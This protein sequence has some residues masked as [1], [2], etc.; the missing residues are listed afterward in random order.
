MHIPDGML[1]AGV[2]AAGYGLTLLATGYSIKKI[3]QSREPARDIP[4]ASL[5]TAAFFVASLVHI[6]V[7]PASVH[8]LLNGLLG[9]IL[10]YYAFPAILVALFLQAVMFGHGGITTLGINAVIM[11]FPAM[12]CSII[13]RRFKNSEQ[14]SISHSVLSF[15]TGSM[16]T[17]L[18]VILFVLIL[19]NF[20]PANI[21]AEAEKIAIYTGA[22]AH[23]PL[24]IIEGILT[25]FV[26]N[27][28]RKVKPELLDTNF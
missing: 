4:K 8:P 26:L 21:N 9:A 7:P 12:V 6:P 28:I 18:S 27:Y 16:G 20:I 14:S 11:G 5:L 1:S 13:Y 23:I 3:N 19:I 10:G 15:V 17:A 2:C 25:A 24:V 22:A